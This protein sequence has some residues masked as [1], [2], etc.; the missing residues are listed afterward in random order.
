MRI[1]VFL[2]IIAWTFA[3]IIDNGGFYDISSFAFDEGVVKGE[4]YPIFETPKFFLWSSPN[5]TNNV[6]LPGGVVKMID[7]YW[8]G[9]SAWNDAVSVSKAI[10]IT[11]K[12]G[13]VPYIQSYSFG[14]SIPQS[15]FSMNYSI[16]FAHRRLQTCHRI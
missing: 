6:V 9:L 5:G 7:T 2:L 13:R 8:A 4:S 16:Y 12:A 15:M 11:I 3:N 10:K 14:D 1:L